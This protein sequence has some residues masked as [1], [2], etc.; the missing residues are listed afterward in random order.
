MKNRG[1]ER[2]TVDPRIMGGK[3]CIR[4]IRI[5]VGTIIG[6]LTSGETIPRILAMYPS[7]EAEDIQAALTYAARRTQEI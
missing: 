1:L 2:I 5:T 3:P 7:L 4:G 6:L